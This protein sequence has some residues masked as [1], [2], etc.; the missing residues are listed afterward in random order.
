MIIDILL[1]LVQNY[2]YCG[3]INT[4]I[5]FSKWKCKPNRPE[6]VR[7]AASPLSAICRHEM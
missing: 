2:R 4:V 7:D 3:K 5:R 1:S 6:I